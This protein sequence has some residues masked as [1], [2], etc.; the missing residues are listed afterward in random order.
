MLRTRLEVVEIT[1]DKQS[2]VVTVSFRPSKVV[3]DPGGVARA[4]D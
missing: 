2:F 1:E 3:L 4:V